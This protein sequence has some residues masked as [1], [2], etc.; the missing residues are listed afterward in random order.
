M[1][2]KMLLYILLISSIVVIGA[3]SGDGSTPSNVDGDK[4]T[5]A[6]G[7][8]IVWPDPDGD[9]TDGDTDGD[10]EQE[11]VEADTDEVSTDGDHDLEAV[12]LVW[13][14]PPPADPMSWPDADAYCAGLVLDG[15]TDW[16]LP[17]ID[18][19]RSLVR[20]CPA[21]EPGS[22]CRISESCAD[23]SDCYDPACDGCEP[24]YGGPSDEGCYI[25]Q[26]LS[27]SCYWTWSSTRKVET[28]SWL[29]YRLRFDFARISYD[30]I[31]RSNYVRCV[32]EIQQNTDVSFISFT[33][34]GDERDGHYDISE[35]D[36][37]C[38]VERL[39][40]P[41]FILYSPENQLPVISLSIW[42]F[43]SPEALQ[44]EGANGA[45]EESG[46]VVAFELANDQAFYEN[47]VRADCTYDLSWDRETERAWGR[48]TCPELRYRPDN[49]RYISVTRGR[50]SCYAPL[51]D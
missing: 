27:G 38:Y 47:P 43:E 23:F 24:I 9:R 39:L 19:L 16:R 8:V 12:E 2:S 1:L 32:R 17:T 15:H 46:L 7:D 37:I 30:G 49:E 33:L 42:D 34:T 10:S 51:V 41:S 14:E 22:V 45:F 20:G 35:G 5:D 18:E 44:A 28:S 21:T 6:D 11:A 13:Q 31:Q 3:C 26:P 36:F 50:F 48:F 29:Y 40:V 4:D 25:D